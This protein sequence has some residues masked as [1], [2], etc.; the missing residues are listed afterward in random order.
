MKLSIMKK[1]FDT[2]DAQWQSPQAD[3]ILS[4]WEHDPGSCYVV[5]ASSN[6]I[7][8]FLAGG[9]KRFLRFAHASQRTPELIHAELD[10]IQHLSDQGIP[11]ARPLPS[12]A[13]RL[14]ERAET[15]LGTCYATVFEAIPGKSLEI[16]EMSQEQIAEWGAT[17][18]RIHNAQEGFL[19]ANRPGW[20]EQLDGAL[21][22]LPSDDIAAQRA[23]HVLRSR[24]G[25]LPV[26]ITNHG[27][28][29]YDL[30]ADN[31]NW[32]GAVPGVFDFDD[33]AHDWLAAD[34]AYALRDLYDDRASR[35]DL[36]DPVLQSFVQ[37]YRSQRSMPEP[38]L[39]NISVHLFKSNLLKYVE[40]QQIASEK[41]EP[42]EP[43]WLVGL[44]KRLIGMTDI[45]CEEIKL[46]INEVDGS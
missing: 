36:K 34:I 21:V 19:G 2:V 29:H 38:E 6:F 9:K 45:Y 24:L 42:G 35:V 3:K 26:N 4:L 44:R 27:L 37:G 31:L 28:I 14:V 32:I 13:G 40:L 46:F 33:C 43:D 7:C 15:S 17:M 5:R 22:N 18:A 23:L 11:A 8:V 1:F 16:N 30:E 41:E 12:L 20:Q 10:F 25:K 39:E